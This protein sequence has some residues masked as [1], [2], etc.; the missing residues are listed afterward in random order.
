M[1]TSKPPE[2]SAEKGSAP[3]KK[4]SGGPMD[5]FKGFLIFAL[6][7]VCAGAGGYFF[8]TMQ[9]FAPIENVPPGTQGAVSST[10]GAAPA[11]AGTPSSLK[12]K[13]W[14]KSYGHD[15]MGY[16]ITAYVNGQIVGK[17]Y[18]PDKQNEITRFV[19]PGENSVRFV[20]EA[21]PESMNEHKGSDYYYLTLAVQ[22]GT[23]LEDSK[24]DTLLNYKRTAAETSAYDDT[25]TF[26]TLE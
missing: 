8:G 17:Y 6:L 18:T 21:L 10:T 2:G 13:Y 7:I 12:K 4:K 25:L 15:H 5:T 9:K 11:T 24:P 19:R 16:S 22:S 20:A 26:V 23:Y 1:T 14:I 3:S